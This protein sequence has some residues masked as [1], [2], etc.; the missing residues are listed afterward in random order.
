MGPGGWDIEVMVWNDYR[1]LGTLPPGAEST[2]SA[3]IDGIDYYA[4]TYTGH[5]YIALAMKQPRTSGTLDFRHIFDWIVAKGWLA[6]NTRLNWFEYGIEIAE[7][8][9]KD[10]TFAVTDFSA[11]GK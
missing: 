8:N 9:G 11:T 7:T 2:D 6:A 10:L 4:W 1:Y 5:T 3:T